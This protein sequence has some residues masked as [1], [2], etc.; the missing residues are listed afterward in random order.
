M[1]RARVG[2]LGGTFDP[3][4]LGHLAL[5]RQV[6][7]AVRLERVIFVPAGNPWQKQ[8]H[9]SV[10]D[11]LAMVRLA[12][13]GQ[14]D[15]DISMVDVERQGPT[16]TIDTLE[17]L[18]TQFPSDDLWFIVGADAA[19]GMSTWHRSEELLHAGKFLVVSRPGEPP[20][21]APEGMRSLELVNI[22]SVDVSSTMCRQAVREGKPLDALVPTAVGEYI[23]EHGLYKE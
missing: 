8:C 13:A 4:H 2:V 19:R 3:I 16:Y 12:I 7:D 20:L 23:S 22:P 15:L 21:Q 9:A 14:E 17:D 1:S 10:E 11:R 5:A 6:R 18:A